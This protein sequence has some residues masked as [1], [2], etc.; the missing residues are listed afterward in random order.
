MQVKMPDGPIGSRRAGRAVGSGHARNTLN[1]LG[2]RRS[3]D[4]RVRAVSAVGTRR[5]HRS[6]G[7]WVVGDLDVQILERDRVHGQRRVTRQGQVIRPFQGQGARKRAPRDGQNRRPRAVFPAIRG[8]VDG[9]VEEGIRRRVPD[10]LLT[11]RVHPG[12]H[13]HPDFARQFALVPVKLLGKQRVV[14]GDR[15]RQRRMDRSRGRPPGSSA[16]QRRVNPGPRRLSPPVPAARR[17]S[18]WTPPHHNPGPPPAT[19]R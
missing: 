1:T 2:S 17:R 19:P 15:V 12:G 14:R 16:R 13:A 10:H 3:W 18:R 11:G 7:T 9:R 4:G 6:G 8:V 5:A